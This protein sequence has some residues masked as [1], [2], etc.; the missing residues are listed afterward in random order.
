MN[1]PA[2]FTENQTRYIKNTLQ[3][4]FNVA[5]GGKRGGKNVMQTLSFCMALE[6]HP[7]K[8]HLIAGVSQTTA[9]LNIVDCDGF[10]LTNYFEGRYR[11]GKYKERACIYV[12]TKTGEKVVLV[13]GGAKKGDEKYIKGNT[14]GMAYVTEANECHPD[15]IQEVFDRTLS[16]ADR[17]IFHDLNPKAPKHWY[18]TDV[19]EYHE[20]RQKEDKSYGYN[21]G[22]FT[23]AD[24]LSVDGDKLKKILKTYQKGTVWYNRD[25]KGNRTPAEGIIYRLLADKPERYTVKKEQLPMLYNYTIGE[26]FGKS[27]SGHAIVLCATGSDGHLYFLKSI[28]KKAEG[29]L[30]ENIVEWSVETFEKFYEEYPYLYDVYPDNAES[31][32]INSIAA[33]SRFNIYPSIKHTIIDRIRVM[34]KLIATGK[35]HFVENECDELI[36]AFS[37][38][39]WDDKSLIDERLDDGTTNVDLLDAAEY[40]AFSYNLHYFETV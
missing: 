5:E 40:A 3:S 1:K 39:L 31:S 2:P 11:E 9:R 22:H 17:K 29:T 36:E 19:L 37:E 23:I 24:N 8:L 28:F 18:Y 6:T 38:A 14:Y 34:N 20:E 30:V 10:G 4:W 7:N 13:S 21:Y 26:D 32:L 15:F 35:V 16:S 25:I 33:K 27:K 12:Q